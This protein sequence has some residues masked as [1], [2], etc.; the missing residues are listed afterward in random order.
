M[1]NYWIDLFQSP[2]L[3]N[4]LFMGILVSIA[5]GITGSY[6][7][8]KRLVFIS[9]GIAHAALG[10]IGV[11]VYFD[12]S[13]TLGAVIS[14]ILFAFIICI[15]RQ[16]RFHRDDTIIGALWAVGMAVGLL[17]A[18][19][20]TD[21]NVDI[22]TYLVGDILFVSSSDLI[23]IAVLTCIII[24]LVFMFHKQFLAVCFDEEFA[25]LQGVKVQPYYFLLLSMIAVTVVMLI[26][27][28]GI[29]LVI[30]LL[31]LPAAISGQYAR[32]VAQMML[33]ASILGII[34]ITT[35]LWVSY[36]PEI[37]SSY[38]IILTAGISYLLSTIFVES[39]RKYMKKTV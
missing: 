4:A 1:M 37:P 22:M 34:F 18:Y 31:S 14:A 33:I 25:Q 23:W 13:P 3:M 29:I 8:V 27:V 30:A 39:K 21:S 32:S 38:A 19:C 6:V 28:V 10:G 20:K 9:G 36:E 24:L 7:V 12:A 26:Q 15:I 16:L 35:G 17:F 2:L 5:C 11:A